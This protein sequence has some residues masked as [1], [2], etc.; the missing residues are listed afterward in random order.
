MVW[1]QSER[2]QHQN[3][4]RALDILKQKL[5]A[6]E[7]ERLQKGIS[8]ERKAQIGSA[9]RSEKIRTYNF[10]QDR[11]TDHRIAKSWHHIN[12]ILDGELDPI[13]ASMTSGQAQSD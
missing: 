11:I 1:C 6:L 9:E 10:P 12:A 5:Y 8:Q 13:V 7:E 4:E 3:K 2:F